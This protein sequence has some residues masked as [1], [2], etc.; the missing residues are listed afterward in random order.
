MENGNTTAFTRRVGTTNYKVKVFFS[1]N[2]GESFEDKIIRLIS[3]RLVT[4]EDLCCG[5]GPQT[6][7]A[8]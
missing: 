3:D 1:D 4:L 2:T 6:E 7:G 5:K 8:A